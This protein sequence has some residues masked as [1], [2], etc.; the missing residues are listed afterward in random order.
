MPA[1]CPVHSNPITTIV[2]D[3]EKLVGWSVPEI[4][5]SHSTVEGVTHT[6]ACGTDVAMPDGSTFF[7]NCKYTA[8]QMRDHLAKAVWP[9]VEAEEPA[10]T[11][12]AAE[13]A[14]ATGVDLT[15]VEGTGKDGVITKA[16]VA[17]AAPEAAA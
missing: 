9:K 8:Q 17:A 11:P 7:A 10:A 1:F 4:V 16:D 14:A 2:D 5:S 3:V 13:H 12:A 15:Q 6:L